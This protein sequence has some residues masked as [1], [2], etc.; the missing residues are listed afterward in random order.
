MSFEERLADPTKYIDLA[1]HFEQVRA[2]CDWEGFADHQQ[3]LD[4]LKKVL[5][6][7][8]TENGNDE[9]AFTLTLHFIYQRADSYALPSED[10][11]QAVYE[12]ILELLG[13]RWWMKETA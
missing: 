12:A 3:C 10:E 7:R 11:V 8:D 4:L 9:I 1:K 5:N 2:Y 6:G 13:A